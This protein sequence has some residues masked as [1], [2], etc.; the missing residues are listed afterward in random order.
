MIRAAIHIALM[1][2]AAAV[3]WWGWSN[4]NLLRGTPVFEFRFVLLLAAGFLVLSAAQALA[5]WLAPP[6]D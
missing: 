2:A 3:L 1:A 5:G 4:L 6:K